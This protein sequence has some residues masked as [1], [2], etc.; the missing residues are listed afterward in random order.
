M[1]RFK[2]LIKTHKWK[3]LFIALLF[4]FVIYHSSGYLFIYNNNS[5]VDANWVEISTGVT[6]TIDHVY[7]Q[8]NQYVHQGD[9][10]LSLNP[11]PFQ[12][13]VNNLNAKI[14][15]NKDQ[16]SLLKISIA[17]MKE[18]I[19]IAKEKL[20]LEDLTYQ[21][22]L[23]L[24][25]TGAISK[26]LFD[27][28]SESY[29]TA[30][31]TLQKSRLQLYYLQQQTTVLHSKNKELQS[32]LKLAQYDLSQ[33]EVFAQKDGYINNLRVYSGDRVDTNQPLFGLIEENSWRIVANIKES[34]LV[35]ITPRKKVLVYIASI[36]WSLHVGTIESIGVG[37]ARSKDQDNAA[38]PYVKPTT[39]W[40]RYAYRIPVRIRIDNP[41]A[42]LYVG[43]N[44]KILVIPWL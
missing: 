19:R 17:E 40:I 8:D 31:S 20:T 6:G 5:H 3:S 32:Q 30:F 37:V 10:L 9:K 36:P 23:H 43:T 42:Q 27:E 35:G 39:S 38:M 41:P 25:K 22:Y 7:I 26:Q 4:Y 15:L 34:N 28:S 44:A 33:S 14:A 24:L 2:Q 16:V 11:K 18:S 12:Y 13:K 1:K 21:R 29:N